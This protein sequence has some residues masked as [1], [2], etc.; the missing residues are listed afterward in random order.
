MNLEA[1]FNFQAADG[2]HVAGQLHSMLGLC[3]SGHLGWGVFLKE[4][5]SFPAVLP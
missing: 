3:G 5:S 2:R 1:S 4:L